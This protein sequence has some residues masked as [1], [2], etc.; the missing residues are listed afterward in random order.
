[1]KFVV[2]HGVSHSVFLLL[3]LFKQLCFANLHC[4]ESL[5]LFEASRFCSTINTGPSPGHSAIV[6]SH[7]NP[8]ALVLQDWFLPLLQQFMNQLDVGKGHL[9]AL[10]QPTSLPSSILPE[11]AS[12]LKLPNEQLS[13]IHVAVGTIWAKD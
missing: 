7:R 12:S 1:M 13:S 10:D 2:C 3:L 8:T 11:P 5:V 9:K 4:N 6:L